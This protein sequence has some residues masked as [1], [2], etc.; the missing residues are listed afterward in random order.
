MLFSV[1]LVQPLRLAFIQQLPVTLLPFG[2]H[3]ERNQAAAYTVLAC[4]LALTDI[5]RHVTVENL[6]PLSGVSFCLRSYRVPQMVIPVLLYGMAV[7]VY[8]LHSMNKSRNSL[9]FFTVHIYLILI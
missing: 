2:I 8:R 9:I 5:F 6:Y 7:S 4:Q 3:D 1:R